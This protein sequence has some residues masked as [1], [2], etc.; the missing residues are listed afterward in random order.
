MAYIVHPWADF[1]DARCDL[2]SRNSV[3]A[4][5]VT[6][7]GSISRRELSED[8]SFGVGAFFVAVQIELEKP[9]AERGVIICTVVYNSR[10]RRESVFVSRYAFLSF[11]FF[12]IFFFPLLSSFFWQCL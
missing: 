7:D 11:L 6:Y 2:H 4:K 8:A 3:G 9:P 1:P 10:Y 12:S 5:K